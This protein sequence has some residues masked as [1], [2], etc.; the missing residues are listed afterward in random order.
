MLHTLLE[1]A[2]THN[3]YAQGAVF[4]LERTEAPGGRIIYRLRSP[5]EEPRSAAGQGRGHEYVRARLNEAFGDDWSFTTGPSGNEWV[6]VI[7][8]PG[9][10][11][12]D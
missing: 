6:D 12:R 7:E 9:S 2:L 4:R 1:N 10:S 11:T 8:M 5:L 3:A